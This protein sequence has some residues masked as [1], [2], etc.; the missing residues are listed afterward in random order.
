MGD[1]DDGFAG[2]F[3]D[4][5]EASDSFRPCER[6]Q[7]AEGF[8]HEQNPGVVRQRPDDGSPLLHAAREFARIVMLKALQGRDLYQVVDTIPVVFGIFPHDF[9]WKTDI[10]QQVPPRQQVGGLEDHADL[11]AGFQN[12][13][14]V[15]GYPSS[16]KRP[17]RRHCPQ[18]G[19]F[20][21][22]AW[23]HDGNELAFFH[24]HVEAVQGLDLPAVSG[25]GLARILYG[26]DG[27][28]LHQ[29]RKQERHDS[30][31]HEGET[32]KPH[33][34]WG[35]IATVKERRK[36]EREYIRFREL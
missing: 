2:L 11:A 28:V 9:K 18:Q 24:G 6:V 3:P 29:I 15:D 17:E 1:K 13:P 16:R 23:A 27:W 21:A 12:L 4:V 35:G 30:T 10:L 14:A 19:A 7:G 36:G 20:A 8:V 26:N 33:A 34:T 22:A 25:K 5:E 31:R 32:L